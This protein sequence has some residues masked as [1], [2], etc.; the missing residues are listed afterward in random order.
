M[1]YTFITQNDDPSIDAN[2]TCLRGYVPL[3]KK[4]LIT[5]FGEPRLCS[6][7]KVV[8]EWLIEVTDENGDSGVITIYDWKNYGRGNLGD[9]FDKWHVGG[10]SNQSVRVLNE[11]L[12]E[13]GLTPCATSS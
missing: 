11:L 3:S 4:K 1:P 12:A 10:H 13:K 7:D 2:G 5:A 9:S 6:G 8:N